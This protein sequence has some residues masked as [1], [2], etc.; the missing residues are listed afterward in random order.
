MKRVKKE[1]IL[2]VLDKMKKAKVLV[3]GDVMLDCFIW[4]KVDRI[5][6]EA[7]VPVVEV[8]RESFMPGG[9]A[10]VAN[11]L[12]SLDVT[13]YLCGVIGD[14]SSGKKLCDIM[15]SQKI[16]LNGLKVLSDR[17]TIVKTRVI[18]HQQQVVRFDREQTHEVR[19]KVISDI[20][21]F[22]DENTN[23]Y[24]AIIVED[25]GKGLV[26]Q[27]LISGLIKIARNKDKVITFD[28]KINRL[29][30][31]S[32]GTVITPN[33]TEGFTFAG[34]DAKR[35]DL[36]YEAGNILL[37]KFGIKY[38]LMTLGEKGMCLFEKGKKPF[39]ISSVAREV[40]DVSG[41]GDTVISALTAAL[42]VGS[43]IRTAAVIANYA[44]GIVVGKLGTATTTIEEIR[45]AV[46]QKH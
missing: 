24:G 34:I 42:A 23:N 22:A 36:L 31:L 41:A 8:A 6:P 40:Y 32:G 9:A 14:D 37:D 1:K 43:D 7:P 10:N 16:D 30:S 18:A 29:F 44:A 26:R 28:P 35:D 5:S 25:Y 3:V 4:G 15:H 13:S 20:L 11:N 39:Q 33:H 27:E 38:V 19:L 21:K 2:K 46:I 17:D 12:R 45:S